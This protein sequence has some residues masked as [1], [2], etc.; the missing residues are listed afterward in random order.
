MT[1]SAVLAQK[2]SSVTTMPAEPVEPIAIST[3]P[4]DADIPTVNSRLLKINYDVS[5]ELKKK[6][7]PGRLWYRLNEGSWQRG[8]QIDAGDPIEFSAG[9]QGVYEFAIDFSVV[10]NPSVSQPAS[11]AARIKCFVDYSKPLLQLIDV[12]Y[13]GGKVLVRWKAFDAHFPDR[14]IEL[15]LVRPSGARLLGK[16]ANSGAA[17]VSVD[18]SELPAQVKII[19]TDR[20]GNSMIE[21]SR[22]VPAVGEEKTTSKPAAPTTAPAITTR[23][24]VQEPPVIIPKPHRNIRDGDRKAALHEYKLASEYRYRGQQDLAILH[25]KRAIEL[26]AEFVDPYI[27]IGSV[28]MTMQ[29]YNDATGFYLQSLGLNPRSVRAWQGLAK[30]KLRTYQYQQAKY[31]LE[32]VVELDKGNVE[33]WLGLGDANWTL[34]EKN[35][36]K[37]AWEQAGELIKKDNLENMVPLLDSRLNL[38]RDLT[39]KK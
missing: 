18:P 38:I 1:A 32:K 35:E 2:S 16:F 23:S 15:Y 8:G 22:T 37:L 24:V 6:H 39:D 5:D 12:G 26:D 7:A 17:V 4:P 33:G 11:S 19:A 20:A 36:A 27:E 25:F 31:C 9:E 28:L 21:L 34:G 3:V 14:P 29:R 10:T 30:A 13:G